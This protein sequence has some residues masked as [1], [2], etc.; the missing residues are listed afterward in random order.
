M[1]LPPAA[2]RRGM[3]SNLIPFPA[4]TRPRSE[5]R[6]PVLVPFPAPVAKPV[7]SLTLSQRLRR[8]V[9][10]LGIVFRNF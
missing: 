2:D 6:R 5:A 4:P 9:R 7:V 10:G 1:L 3:S 8:F